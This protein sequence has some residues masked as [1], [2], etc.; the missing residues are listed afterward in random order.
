MQYDETLNAEEVLRNFELLE[1]GLMIEQNGKRY[2]SLK[3]F[4]QALEGMTIHGSGPVV[5]VISNPKRAKVA[6]LSQGSS[7]KKGY[8]IVGEIGTVL[9]SPLL[10]LR[11]ARNRTVPLYNSLLA[12]G[13][14]R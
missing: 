11:Y 13:S 10:V 9:F 8:N 7:S 3:D 5:S 1:K 4:A 14:V 6:M 2:E 12:S